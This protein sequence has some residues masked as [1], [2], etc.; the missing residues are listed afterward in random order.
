MSIA[1]KLTTIAEN[2]QKVYDSG[3]NAGKAAG[4]GVETDSPLYYAAS[5]SDAY[6]GV[7]FPENYHAVIKLQKVVQMFQTFRG[8]KNLTKVTL[9]SDDT[10]GDPYFRQ[11][12]RECTSLETIDL[13]RYNRKL[14]ANMSYWCYGAMALKSII[15]ALDFAAS[16]DISSAFVAH[17]LVDVEIV[18][19]T[20]Y[21]D[22][23]FS[24]AY[25]SDASIQSIIDGLADL[26][27]DTAKTLTLN[28]V[29]ASLTDEQKAA[30]SAKNWTLVY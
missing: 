5:L 7:E 21:A 25:L 9:I 4:G 11:T 18:P 8:A 26:T 1:D 17:S 19:N 14:N 27:G 3:Y 30:I 10:S 28:G 13:T 12:F 15:G 6:N 23:R 2:V 24:S 20:I 22:I 29:G 16:T